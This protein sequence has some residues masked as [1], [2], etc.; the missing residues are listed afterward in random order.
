M[1]LFELEKFSGQLLVNVLADK[2]KKIKDI[3]VKNV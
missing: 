3:F 1:K 2:M